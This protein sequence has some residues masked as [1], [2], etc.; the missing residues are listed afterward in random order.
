MG[1]HKAAAALIVATLLG[2]VILSVG[3]P[4]RRLSRPDP[5]GQAEQG[6]RQTGAA[7]QVSAIL[8]DYRAL[9]TLGEA[10]V[11]LTAAAIV[12][13]FST[14]S[15][16]TMLGTELSV[17]VRYG[18]G[19]VLPF[20]VLFGFFIILFGHVSPGGGFT[21]GVVLAAAAIVHTTVFSRG[22]H[23]AQLVRP[24]VGKALEN[25]GLLLFLGAGLAG[26]TLGG[27]FLA[28]AATGIPLGS[29]GA[30]ASGGLIP[31]LN[32]FSGLKVGAGLALIFLSLSRE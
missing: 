9:D 25:G 16:I 1:G 26:L 4:L 13:F 19:L 10:S 8:F 24:E 15:R 32:L 23:R 14:R 20:I 11:I 5:A 3:P 12:G 22:E 2:I 21:G 18:V 17:I 7:N 30:L 6:V 29:P 27:S 28:N 31:F